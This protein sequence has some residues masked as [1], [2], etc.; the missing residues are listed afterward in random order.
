MTKT[1]QEKKDDLELH[2]FRNN[3]KSFVWGSRD[4]MLFVADCLKVVTGVDFASMFRGRYCNEQQALRLIKQET[5]AE[6]FVD[7]FKYL[8]DPE[9]HV[10]KSGFEECFV[11][12][13]VELS[14]KQFGAIQH[15]G[16]AVIF[17]PRRYLI[18]DSNFFVEKWGIK[19]Q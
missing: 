14:G 5:G 9:C 4:C 18:V 7:L 17:Q 3:G 11:F 8:F 16:N 1:A 13:V 12:G 15:G 2:I 10:H 19:W 6:N